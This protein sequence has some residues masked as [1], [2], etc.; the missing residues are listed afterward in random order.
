MKILHDKEFIINTQ[1]KKYK[2]KRLLRLDDNK[3]TLQLDKNHKI[4]RNVD[5][6]IGDDELAEVVF[7]MILEH[8][9]GEWYDEQGKSI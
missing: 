4:Q 7:S 8:Q 3:Y 9:D 1:G 2:F 5:I 6:N